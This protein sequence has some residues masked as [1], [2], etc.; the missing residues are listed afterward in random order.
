V[1]G[2]WEQERV[3]MPVRSYENYPVN[4]AIK[5][6]LPG[7]EFGYDNE[8]KDTT[9]QFQKFLVKHTEKF[10]VGGINIYYKLGLCA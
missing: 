7:R 3:N 6:F 2:F 9:K 8:V 1:L 5:S 10:K 4:R